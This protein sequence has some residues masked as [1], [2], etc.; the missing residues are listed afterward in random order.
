MRVPRASHER[1]GYP[2][3][4]FF[5]SG[6]RVDQVAQPVEI[7][8]AAEAVEAL[9]KAVIADRLA[10]HVAGAGECVLEPAKVVA[11]AI[12]RQRQIVQCL[13]LHR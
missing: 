12:D 6:Q 3:N 11:C 8:Q 4:D 9:V 1:R 13:N 7:D 2:M 5:S 10:G